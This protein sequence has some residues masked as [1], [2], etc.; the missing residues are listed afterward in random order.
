MGPNYTCRL[1][2]HVLTN[3]ADYINEFLGFP[4]GS[5][6]KNPPVKVETR[7]WSLGQGDPL[8]KEMATHSSTLAWRI[9]WTEEPGGLQV[10]G[11]Q[12]I[13]HDWVTFT[14]TTW[15]VLFRGQGFRGSGYLGM[16]P[17]ADGWS[18]RNH[19][20]SFKAPTWIWHISHPHTCSIGRSN[21]HSWAQH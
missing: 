5:M 14:L 21:L 1:L 11:S 3:I 18:A 10:T 2:V 16:L 12:R 8:E 7:V 13:G 20:S 19:V 17:M 9:L 6:V 4:G 15:C